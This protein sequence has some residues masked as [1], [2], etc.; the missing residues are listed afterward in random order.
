MSALRHRHGLAFLRA[1]RRWIRQRSAKI[2]LDFFDSLATQPKIL[3][4]AEA[5]SVHGVA[6]IFHE[7]FIALHHHR[8]QLEPFDKSDLGIPA[9]LFE[10][11]LA[12]VIVPIGARKGK[13]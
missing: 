9:V 8:L 6:E 4:I 1:Y 5:F 2:A 12:D 11:G 7:R 13:I 10:G 3:H